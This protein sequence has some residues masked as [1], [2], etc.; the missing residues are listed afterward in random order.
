MKI[1]NILKTI[2]PYYVLWSYGFIAFFIEITGFAVIPIVVEMRGK[3]SYVPFFYALCV[4]FGFIY[5]AY[6]KTC[7]LL[8]EENKK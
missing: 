5:F 6:Y 3:E 4:V 7:K 1:I 8:V 2:E